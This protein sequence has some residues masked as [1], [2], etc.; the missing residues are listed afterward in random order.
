MRALRI[1]IPVLVTFA[2]AAHGA[3]E[4]WSEGI[5][6]IGAGLLLVIWA[7][8]AAVR[9]QMELRWNWLVAP[10]AGV[11]A[12]A[13]AQ[14]AVGLTVSPYA[15]RVE[16]LRIT[17]ELILVFLTVQAFR[18]PKEWK[19]LVWF[20][21]SLAFVVS[22]FGIV[23][24][25][26]YNGKLYWLRTLHHGGEPFG[27][28][29]NRDDFAGFVELILPLGLALLVLDGERRER[30]LLVALFVVF[31]AAALVLSAS[32]AG[33]LCFLGE[34]VLL[35]YLVWLYG[36]RSQ[37]YL[38]VILALAIAGIAAW[39]G[40]G[41][42]FSRFNEKGHW[43]GVTLS[44][45]MS[46]TRDTWR[47]FLDHPYVGTG[48][49]TFQTAYPRYETQYTGLVINHAHNDYVEL[50]SDGG[51]VGGAFGLLFLLVLFRRGTRNVRRAMSP[52]TRSLYGG[53]LVGAI[54]LLGHELV[55]FNLHVPSNAI[56][57]LVISVLAT[58]VIPEP[59]PNPRHRGFTSHLPT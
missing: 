54:G 46:L 47:I 57:F 39:L 30:R 12:L 5:L 44:Q 49:G 37:R 35:G 9:G 20:L 23:Q 18:T 2:V 27:P 48:M 28:F 13:L 26:T 7:V 42:A 17:A 45:R 59:I 19:N 3:V 43:S 52:V 40:V 31:P 50:L 51:L 58:T 38:L 55:D 21:M 56:I 4:P 11:L 41:K 34:L 16:A 8:E 29:V 1:G 14:L 6:E 22:I 53:G 36:R 15:T 24:Y 10:V 33:I 25:F 32:R